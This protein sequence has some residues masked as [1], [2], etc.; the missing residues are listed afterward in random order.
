MFINGLSA[1][2]YWLYWKCGQHIIS[3]RGIVAIEEEMP[4]KMVKGMAKVNHVL[5]NGFNYLEAF[6]QHPSPLE[7][8]FR[9]GSS[10]KSYF[11][12]S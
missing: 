2:V 8:N 1:G 6:L 10:D 3:T 5:L 9:I 7:L 11:Y 4:T 12:F